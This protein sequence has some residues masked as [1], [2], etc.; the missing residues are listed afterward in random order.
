MLQD[1]D[2]F[3]KMEEWSS[4]GDVLA[5]VKWEESPSPDER[6]RIDVDFRFRGDRIG[7]A[8]VTLE[9][10]FGIDQFNVVWRNI[11]FV[12]EW[13]NKNLYTQWL[14]QWIIHGPAYGITRMSGAPVDVKAEAIYMASGFEWTPRGFELDMTGQ[15]ANEWLAYAKGETEQPA[16]RH[17]IL[18]RRGLLGAAD[19]I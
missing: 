9:P 17:A 5:T 11:E 18:A 15:K 14:A 1:T 6:Y 19:A 13:Q 2:F 8:D 12:P 10:I 4:F 7:F 3:D 16:W